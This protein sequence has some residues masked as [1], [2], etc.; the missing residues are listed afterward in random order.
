MV[1]YRLRRC[2]KRRSGW[3][4]GFIV[5]SELG[6]TL[7]LCDNRCCV[8]THDALFRLPVFALLLRDAGADCHVASLIVVS[9]RVLPRQPGHAASR[10]P[11]QRRAEADL[12][13]RAARRGKPVVI[14]PQKHFPLKVSLLQQPPATRLPRR[15]FVH[16]CQL[17]S[18]G[19]RGA[20]RERAVHAGG[21]AGVRPLRA[22]SPILRGADNG[23]PGAPWGVRPAAERVLMLHARERGL[24]EGTRPRAERRWKISHEFHLCAWSV[25]I[26]RVV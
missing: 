22:P 9:S 18:N 3:L 13:A 14:A 4:R 10:R 6:E 20:E 15:V 5:H 23:Q 21:A 25:R 24:N 7:N 26:Q 8:F 12:Q 1:K 19:R 11:Q 16:H 17:V 2:T